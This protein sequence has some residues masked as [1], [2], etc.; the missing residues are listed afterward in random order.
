L[1]NGH[2][3]ASVPTKTPI[4]AEGLIHILRALADDFPAIFVRFEPER[5]MG[6]RRFGWVSDAEKRLM[7]FK[8]L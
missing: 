7:E 4:D 3:P 5:P 1:E 2:F 8:G 6:A